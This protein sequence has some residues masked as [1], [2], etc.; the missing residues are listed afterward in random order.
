MKQRILAALGACAL[1]A[2][3]TTSLPPATTQPHDATAHIDCGSCA[4]WNQPQEP[5]NVAGNTWYVGP[6]GLAALLVTSPQGHILLDGALPQSAPQIVANIEKL[7]FRI[8]D[9]KLIVNSHAHWDHAG[10]IA[11]LQQRSGAQV[12]ASAHSARVL[13]DGKIGPD[14]P[15][16]NP[17]DQQGSPKVAQVREVQDG[18]TL[19]VGPLRITAHL[20]PGHTPGSTTWT[21]VS[22][23]TGGPCLNMVYADSLTAISEDNAF[24]F[25]GARAEQ[26][27]QSIAKV[28]ALP[29]DVI[30]STHPSFTDTFDKLKARTGAKPTSNNTFITPGGCRAYARDAQKGLD[31]RLAKEQSGTV[32]R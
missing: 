1:G 21:W 31:E 9:V 28:A 25:T 17:V 32:G 6:Q 30:V 15:Q 19:A 16:Y 20:T 5:F 23:E 27:R 11:A 8:E 26:F 18:E 4:E 10:G 3:S 29:C 12:A 13:R 24:R 22:C 7:G 14:D 2:C